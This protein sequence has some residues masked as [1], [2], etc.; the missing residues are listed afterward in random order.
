MCVGAVCVFKVFS[1]FHP[2]EHW[3]SKQGM[4]KESSGR[5]KG[6]KFISVG[7]SSDSGTQNPPSVLWL[8]WTSK[9]LP[10][11]PWKGRDDEALS[12]GNTLLPP[13]WLELSHMSHQGVKEA[14]SCG[15]W[16]PRKIRKWGRKVCS[17]PL[18]QEP[19]WRNR[20][21]RL[22]QSRLWNFFSLWQM[23]SPGDIIWCWS[24]LRSQ[25]SE[26][27]IWAACGPL[28]SLT[29]LCSWPVPAVG[30]S[31]KTPFSKKHHCILQ[32]EAKN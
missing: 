22:H 25:T 26:S 17:M 23:M 6:R 12:M 19:S 24:W 8:C 21:M 28:G 5:G 27:L 7:G 16:T 20:Q 29:W 1:V 15:L 18:L 14:G 11:H 31:F 2:G 30:E 9:I 13:S 3:D 10:C 32:K 4:R